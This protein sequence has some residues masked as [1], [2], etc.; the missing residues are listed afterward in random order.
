MI[1]IIGWVLTIFLALSSSAHAGVDV[2]RDLPPV[3]PEFGGPNFVENRLGIASVTLPTP[4]V[5]IDGR[6]IAR[7]VPPV[8]TAEIPNPSFF[9]IGG[10]DTFVIPNDDEGGLDII[11]D[12]SG[13]PMGEL[14]I[15]AISF[16]FGAVDTSQSPY[17][18]I[19]TQLTVTLND[20]AFTDV[21][22][23][24]DAQ[25]VWVGYFNPGGVI[26]NA[27]ITASNGRVAIG[28]F[29]YGHLTIPEPGSA[30]LLLTTLVLVGARRRV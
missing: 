26:E 21:V 30:A 7:P 29:G 23:I 17:A 5:D 15:N 19:N 24:T 28:T 2:Y 11:Y 20:G 27:R 12:E 16:V 6:V 22:N 13:P 8:F 4:F 25:P 18:F 1:R 9:G 14:P 10:S 3:F